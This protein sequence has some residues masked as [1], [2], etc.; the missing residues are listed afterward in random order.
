[1]LWSSMPDVSVKFS[2]DPIIG[3]VSTD[4]M[5]WLL[6]DFVRRQYGQYQ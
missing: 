4:N 1:M 5:V 2:T 3:H 6:V